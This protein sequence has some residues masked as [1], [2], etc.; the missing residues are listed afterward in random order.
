MDT[1]TLDPHFSTQL[2]ERYALYLIYNTDPAK[3][4]PAITAFL[5][6][7]RGPDGQRVLAGL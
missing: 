7:V 6:F 3:I 5:E 1:K 4:R 2:S